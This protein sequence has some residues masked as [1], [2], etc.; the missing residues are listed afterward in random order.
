MGKPA[1]RI[2]DMHTCTKSTTTTPPVAHVGGTIDPTG[3]SPNVNI[4][5]QAAARV[6]DPVVCT[7]DPSDKNKITAGSST[8]FI[9]GQPAARMGDSTKHLGIITGGCPNVN[10]G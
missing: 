2:G 8:V 4:G 9:N 6:N 5:G 7:G 3:G 1:A 10:F